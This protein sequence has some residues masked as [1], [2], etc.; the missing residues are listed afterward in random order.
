MLGACSQPPTCL[1]AR[2]SGFRGKAPAIFSAFGSKAAV[3]HCAPASLGP[4]DL[5]S[6]AAWPGLQVPAGPGGKPVRFPAELSSLQTWACIPPLSGSATSPQ[7]WAAG[8][9][10][11]LDQA[12]PRGC[13]CHRPSFAHG[14]AVSKA[15]PCAPAARVPELPPLPR[16]HP[17]T[18][19]S[20]SRHDGPASREVPLPGVCRARSPAVTA[21][22]TLG[23][24]PKPPEVATR[25]LMPPCG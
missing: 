24:V 2:W 9:S 17:R 13:R 4:R 25:S 8:P 15:G 1:A 14:V 11:R 20:V 6:L 10:R 3:Q 19:P 18:V 7:S 12:T 22:A 21:Q 23:S 5:P 16:S